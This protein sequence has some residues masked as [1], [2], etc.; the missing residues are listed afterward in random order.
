MDLYIAFGGNSGHG[1]DIITGFSPAAS[2]ASN[3]DMVLAGSKDSDITM[4]SGSRAGYSH[5]YGLQTWLQ[6][7]PH[8]MEVCLALDG[9]MCH[10]HH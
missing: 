4:A 9:N 10:R 8:I 1:R 5:Q 6:A 2:G 3:P 7:V